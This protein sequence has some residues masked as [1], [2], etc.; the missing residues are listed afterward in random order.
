M[1]NELNLNNK[2]IN[3]LKVKILEIVKKK[4]GIKTFDVHIMNGKEY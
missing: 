1:Q 3:Q 4:G 2:T